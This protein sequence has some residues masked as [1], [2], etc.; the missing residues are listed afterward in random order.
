MP[1]GALTSFTI[2]L[3]DA[4]HYFRGQEYFT[5]QSMSRTEYL[6]RTHSIIVLD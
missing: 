1:E 5:S 3:C 6:K 2:G 4:Y